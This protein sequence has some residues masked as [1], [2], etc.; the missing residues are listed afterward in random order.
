MIRGH[1]E[2]VW[3]SASLQNRAIEVDYRMRRQVASQF[4]FDS[5]IQL[6]RMDEQMQEEVFC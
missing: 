1:W 6:V 2:P 5:G 3:C 4:P